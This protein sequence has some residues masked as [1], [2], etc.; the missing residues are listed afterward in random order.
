MKKVLIVTSLVF[1]L[2]AAYAAAGV[3]YEEDFTG[4]DGGYV[5]T[6][7]GEI[8]GPWIYDGSSTWTVNGSENVGA[9]THSRLTSPA[10][11]VTA[12]GPVE[13]SFVHRYSIEGDLWDGAAVFTSINGGG[14][15]QVPGDSF[16]ANGYTGQGLVGNHDL[17]GGEGFNGDS[18]GYG[19]PAFITSIATLGTLATGDTVEVQFL[20]AWDEFS[21]GTEPNWQID[22]VQLSVV[23][24]PGTLA[25]T[26]CLALFGA[27]IALTRR[28]R[29]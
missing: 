18:P 28:G 10:V 14:F 27:T 5:V 8:E 6:N 3:I 4:G 15:T 1:C 9:P 22:S 26:L 17:N 12:D 25:L 13:L 21:K 16:S 2:S 29:S 24:E 19:D 11:A 20:G 7:T 23:P